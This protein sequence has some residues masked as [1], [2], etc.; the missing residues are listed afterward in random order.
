MSYLG[1]RPD[2]QQELVFPD[3]SAR[4]KVFFYPGSSIGNFDPD[5]ALELFQKIV[6]ACSGDG[7]LLIGVDLLKDQDV[8]YRAYNDSLGVTAAFNKNVLLHLNRLV[9]TDF[10]PA[11]WSHDALFNETKQRIEMYL[12]ATTKQRVSWPS[13]E[14]EFAR[15]ERIHT[16]NSYKYDRQAFE[17]L[18]LRAGFGHVRSWTDA[19]HYF[20]VSYAAA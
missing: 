7:G 15:N 17:S 3:L 10:D 4:K 12:C 16:E 8:L 2:L 5:E 9:G 11:Y 14:R 20:L 19:K 13:G 6:K 18:L 1:S